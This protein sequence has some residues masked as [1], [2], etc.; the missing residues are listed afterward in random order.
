[1][2]G[3][4]HLECNRQQLELELGIGKR[5]SMLLAVDVYYRQQEAQVAGVLFNDWTDAQP[6]KVIV[7][8]VQEPAEYRP[9]EFFRRELPC[10]LSLLELV[11]EAI[12][13]KLQ[14]IIIDGFVF[15]NEFRKP[16][17]GKHLY[18]ALNASIAII[19]VAKS[20]FKGIADHYV[21]KR[22]HSLRPLYV[23]CEGISLPEA[24]AN[25]LSMHG[26]YRMPTLLKLAD[27]ASRR[28]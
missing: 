24:K 4:V 28:I 14:T 12:N 23:T 13:C 17:L 22:G 10:I 2:H 20:P 9:G 18:D 15:L 8:S 7:C 3:N 6:L 16:G 5:L 21:L 19:G 26:D 1:M 27:T 11:D 25:I